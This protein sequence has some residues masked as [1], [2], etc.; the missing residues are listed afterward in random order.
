MRTQLCRVQYT[1]IWSSNL[2]AVCNCGVTCCFCSDVHTCPDY[3]SGKTVSFRREV[4]YNDLTSNGDYHRMHWAIVIMVVVINGSFQNYLTFGTH[5]Q[6][7]L[8]ANQ[9]AC[10]VKD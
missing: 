4:S 8:L 2:R 3:I 9:C 5:F 10:M 6:G 7:T 1:P